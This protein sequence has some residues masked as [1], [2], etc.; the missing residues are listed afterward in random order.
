MAADAWWFSL[1]ATQSPYRARS[2][3]G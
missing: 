1:S 2:T 3:L